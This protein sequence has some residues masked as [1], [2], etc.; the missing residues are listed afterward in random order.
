MAYAVHE[1]VVPEHQERVRASVLRAFRARTQRVLD[2]LADA[3]DVGAV[4]E[5]RARRI[6]L[7]ER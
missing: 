1:W 2:Q 4:T 6:A 7:R 3:A 5:H